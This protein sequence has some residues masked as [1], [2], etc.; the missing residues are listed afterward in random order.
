M[1]GLRCWWGLH[2]NTTYLFLSCLFAIRLRVVFS[3]ILNVLHKRSHLRLFFCPANCKHKRRDSQYASIS[4]FPVTLLSF[5]W[6]FW[7]PWLE[8]TSIWE[9]SC[10]WTFPHSWDFPGHGRADVTKC[11]KWAQLRLQ[12]QQV[13]YVHILCLVAAGNDSA[14]VNISSKIHRISAA[15]PPPS[16]GDGLATIIELLENRCLFLHNIVF[17]IDLFCKWDVWFE[18]AY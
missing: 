2:C 10:I 13:H 12:I 7:I 1:V 15:T 9:L 18:R 5:R 4:P 16:D 11:D 14:I 8:F 6:K 3:P 17:F